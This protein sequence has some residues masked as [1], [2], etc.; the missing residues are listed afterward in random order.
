MSRYKKIVGNL[1][2]VW[3]FDPP[4]QEYFFSCEDI[5]GDEDGEELYLFHIGSKVTLIEHVDYPR[6]RY[7]TNGEMLEV[8]NKYPG[9]VPKKH[10]D[11]IALDIQFQYGDQIQ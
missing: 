7:F 2:Y 3:G 8:M 4:L 9:I 11:A 6:K 10:L 1:E 5:N